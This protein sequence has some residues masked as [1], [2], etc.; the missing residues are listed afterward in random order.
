MISGHRRAQ[1]TALVGWQTTAT[2]MLR[3]YQIKMWQMQL[4]HLSIDLCRFRSRERLRQ[5][6]AL[7]NNVLLIRCLIEKLKVQLFVTLQLGQLQLQRRGGV[8][9][10]RH[11]GEK[12][13]DPSVEWTRFK[14]KLAWL[15]QMGFL[16]EDALLI[17]TNKIDKQLY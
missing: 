11:N 14:D 16:G 4:K 6:Y 17:K 13:N 8:Q 1:P 15:C 7:V 2:E 10:W 9:I 3:I 12:S 5:E